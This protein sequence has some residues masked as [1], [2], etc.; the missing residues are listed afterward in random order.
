MSTR[1][2]S[3]VTVQDMRLEYRVDKKY[4]TAFASFLFNH[5]I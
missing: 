2:L 1:K 5:Y 3:L 4:I